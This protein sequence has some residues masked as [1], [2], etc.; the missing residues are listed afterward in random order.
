ME[1]SVIQATEPRRKRQ[2]IALEEPDGDSFCGKDALSSIVTHA[3]GLALTRQDSS[4]RSLSDW[5]LSSNVDV[6]QELTAG[7]TPDRNP[8]HQPIAIA[9]AS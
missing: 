5:L 9:A 1:S 7:P 8:F 4:A 3:S 2:R 6:S